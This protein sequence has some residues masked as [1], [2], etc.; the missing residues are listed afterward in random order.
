M[1]DLNLNTDDAEVRTAGL[2]AGWGS[3]ALAYL[4]AD[5][6]RAVDFELWVTTFAGVP[7]EYPE[8][9]T[10]DASLQSASHVCAL[11]ARILGV[12]KP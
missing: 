2:A 1:T 8:G 9:S 6:E 7:P 5:P 3:A 11:L 10:L 4:H 12:K